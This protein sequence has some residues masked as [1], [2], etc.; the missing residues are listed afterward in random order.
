MSE[1][2]ETSVEVTKRLKESDWIVIVALWERGEVTLS[3]LSDRF[4]IS[5]AGL[6]Q[7]LKRRGA[8]RG[9]KAHIATKKIQE[10]IES[11]KEK[12]VEDIYNFKKRHI[13]YG[14][15][16]ADMAVETVRA[17]KS[18]GGVGLANCRGDLA[19]IV[20]AVKVI[21]KVRDN[22]Y[23][24][25]D[26]YNKENVPSENMDFNIGVYSEKDVDALRE[27]QKFFDDEEARMRLEADEED[28]DD[29]ENVEYGDEEPEDY[30]GLD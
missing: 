12:L 5:K 13:G 7:G 15:Y 10:K 23:H 9:S 1:E 6:S 2:T 29:I 18:P 8:V 27:A 22:L 24:L 11:E 26:L 28:A 17:A 16:L 19:S 14:N 21:D 4:T 30:K 20:E 3:E 25:Y